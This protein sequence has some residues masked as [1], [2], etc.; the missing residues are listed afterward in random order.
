[1]NTHTYSYKLLGVILFVG[2]AA[3]ASTLHAQNTFALPFSLKQSS[4]ATAF[5]IDTNGT[6]IASGPLNPSVTLTLS[7]SPQMVW[8]PALGAFRVGAFSDSQSTIGQYSV[9][10]GL[11]STVSG[12]YSAAFGLYNTVNSQCSA[13]FGWGNT[14]SGY[15]SFAAGYMCNSLGDG[16]V[17]LGNS[18]ATGLG[19]VAMGQA[20]ASGTASVGMGLGTASG[21]ASVGMELGTASGDAATAMGYYSQANSYAAVAAGQYNVGLSSTGATPNATSWVA[22]DPLLEVGNGTSSSAK[23][24]AL[25]IYKNGTATFQGVVTVAAGG[26]IP[27]YTGN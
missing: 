24:D 17:A 23:A 22:T 5:S 10:F 7:N 13:A 20:S 6:L 8:F 21:T 2:G 25:V 26:D 4:P 16:S 12:P 19:A 27:M 1:M 14:A 15:A 9:A 3:Y 18:S 11:D